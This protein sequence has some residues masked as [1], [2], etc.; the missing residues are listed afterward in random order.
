MVSVLAM[1]A[2]KAKQGTKERAGLSFDAIGKGLG[3][4]EQQVKDLIHTNIFQTRSR[5]AADERDAAQDTFTYDPERGSQNPFI[6]KVGEIAGAVAEHSGDPSFQFMERLAR[7]GGALAG[8]EGVGAAAEAFTAPVDPKIAGETFSRN[9]ETALEVPSQAVSRAFIPAARIGDTEPGQ[10]FGSSLLS[11]AA[12]DVISKRVD[13]PGPLRALSRVGSGAAQALALSKVGGLALRGLGIGAGGAAAS[14][15]GRVASALKGAGRN[16]FREAVEAGITDGGVLLVDKFAP[17]GTFVPT[18]KGLVSEPNRMAEFFGAVVGGGVL[19]GVIG[20]ATGGLRKSKMADVMKAMKEEAEK[21]DAEGGIKADE[22]YPLAPDPDAVAARVSRERPLLEGVDAP[23]T[24]FPNLPKVERKSVDGSAPPPKISRREV[25]DRLLKKLVETGV[26]KTRDEAFDFVTTRI[27]RQL[28]ELSDKEFETLRLWGFAEEGDILRRGVKQ[29]A[30]GGQEPKGGAA[31]EN[32]RDRLINDFVKKGVADSPEE[33]IEILAEFGQIAEDLPPRLQADLEAAGF[34]DTT[35]ENL[36]GLEGMRPFPLHRAEAGE[37]PAELSQ[38]RPSVDEAEIPRFTQDGEQGLFMA[39]KGGGADVP[40]EVAARAEGSEPP[41]DADDGYEKLLDLDTAPWYGKLWTLFVQ[42]AAMRKAFN[43]PGQKLATKI[44]GAEVKAGNAAGEALAEVTPLL[45]AL[46]KEERGRFADV[47]RGKVAAKS[48]AETALLSWWNDY[49]KRTA[50]RARGLLTIKGSKGEVVWDAA[51]EGYYPS[52]VDVRALN[53]ALRTEEGR[54]KVI[55]EMV[56]EKRAKN[57]KDAAAKIKGFMEDRLTRRH[58]H[59]EHAKEAH[60]PDRFY[61]RDPYKMITEYI[62][63]AE[64][65]L[66]DAEFM[67]AKYE[68]L[69]EAL[70]E[71][72]R[73]NSAAD[74][75][76]FKRVARRALE[77]DNIGRPGDPVA[78]ASRAARSGMTVARLSLAA[79]TNI[80]DLHKTF[81]VTG[82]NPMSAIRGI[83]SMFTDQG[84]LNAMR[85]GVYAD[86]M[87]RLLAD[88]GQTRLA[89]RFLNITGFNATERGIRTAMVNTVRN[90]AEVLMKRLEANPNNA[91]AKRRMIKYLGGEAD[92]DLA[93]KHWNDKEFR[94]RLLREAGARM[95]SKSQPVSR[96]DAPFY[97]S[98]PTGRVATQFKSFALKHMEFLREFVWDEAMRKNPMPLL[99][100]GITAQLM[101]EPVGNVKAWIRGKKR[102]GDEE[103]VSLMNMVAGLPVVQSGA[104]AF[105]VDLSHKENIIATKPGVVSRRLVD[106]MLQIGGI[107]LATDFM[108]AVQHQR[109]GGLLNFL[110]GPSVSALDD[111]A[112]G[113]LTFDPKTLG[114]EFTEMIPVVGP[115]TSRGGIDL[116]SAPLFI[117]EGLKAAGVGGTSP[118]LE[119]FFPRTDEAREFGEVA[120]GSP[121]RPK[122]VAPPFE[123]GA[124][125]LDELFTEGSGGIKSLGDLAAV[126]GGKGV[127]QVDR[128]RAVKIARAVELAERLGDE[129]FFF[130]DKAKEAA[131]Q[132]LLK[133]L[134]ELGKDDTPKKIKAFKLKKGR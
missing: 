27:V 34:R 36:I 106:N 115:A 14:T 19:G 6:R 43:K 74:V 58:G 11:A 25:R 121:P 65:R 86:N 78:A 91:F 119:D 83:A 88:T 94:E 109:W 97:W 28:D 126:F 51:S 118:G 54:N 29:R 82:G 13:L 33:A 69:D 53:K 79:I 117:G 104:D 61:Q 8:G 18:T 15:G 17:E 39:G 87:S 111:M 123:Q 101:G 31:Q 2:F 38:V 44:E 130:T 85:S 125:V 7:G 4:P 22:P 76:M 89:E 66:A 55:A 108:S 16:A 81:V 98:T 84:R 102:V 21:I 49:A 1:V 10:G 50:G 100:L 56:L 99:M 60:L 57:A 42:N 12:P 47:V 132:E 80:S 110:V 52:S 96:V 68:A 45:R 62:D 103:D 77:L 41:K 131:G 122:M 48:E 63:G 93:M 95:I 24:I 5:Q 114:K 116:E 124:R 107:G 113:A 23:D 127:A 37:V 73:T 46:T 105:G 75:E 71:Y 70:V 128:K 26:F 64:R 90:H 120:F 30:K 72:G 59:L 32:F 67:G 133:L 35:G 40:P 129:T 9:V 3:I 134:N 20:G 92:F 112:G